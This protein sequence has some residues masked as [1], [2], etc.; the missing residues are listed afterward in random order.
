MERNYLYGT[1]VAALHASSE[2]IIRRPIRHAN[3]NVSDQ[4][5]ASQCCEDLQ[6]ILEGAIKE[7]M[8]L[9][10]EKFV[11]F[12]VVL[13]ISDSFVRHHVRHLLN[14]IFA[15]MRFKSCF[16][17]VESVMATYAMAA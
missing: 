7:K 13:V 15:K 12:N 14:M 9:M 16:V 10:P 3:L 2:F 6:R 11:N 4:Y 8:G 5:S 1:E 17:H